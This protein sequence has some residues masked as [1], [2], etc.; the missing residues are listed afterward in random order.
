MSN[1]NI[2]VYGL[3]IICV[4]DGYRCFI[5]ITYDYSRYSYIYLMKHKSELI[6]DLK[7]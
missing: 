7:N 6:K 1:T 3:I 2:D 5:T 4:I